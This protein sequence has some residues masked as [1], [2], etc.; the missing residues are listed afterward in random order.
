[1]TEQDNNTY[2][3]TA[4]EWHYRASCLTTTTNNSAWLMNAEGCSFSLSWL[5]III[6]QSE[7]KRK[8]CLHS[9]KLLHAVTVLVRSLEFL[10]ST[11]LVYFYF[12]PPSLILLSLSQ[13]T[14]TERWSGF[15]EYWRWFCWCGVHWCDRHRCTSSPF[16][17]PWTERVKVMRSFQTNGGTSHDWSSELV[18]LA[19][20][21]NAWAYSSF[22]IITNQTTSAHKL[23]GI[24]SW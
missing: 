16:R 7:S 22:T 2:I 8:P 4:K 19:K 21:E 9:K 3:G 24:R 13:L 15:F 17:S 10:Y 23:R 1:M 12:T 6:Y 18:S 5:I 11:N 20:E 14:F